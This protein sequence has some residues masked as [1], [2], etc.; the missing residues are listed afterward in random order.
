MHGSILDGNPE[1]GA[2][3]EQSMLFDLSKASS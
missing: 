3:N 1:K 2:R